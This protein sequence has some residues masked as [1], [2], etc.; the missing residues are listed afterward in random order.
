MPRLLTGAD[1]ERV[2]P[3]ELCIAAVEDALRQHAL[4][5]VPEPG[6][7]GMH[8]GV[9]SFHVKAGSLRVE[10]KLYFAAK[11]NANFPGNPG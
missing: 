11:L 1:V 8:E 6:I 7:L 5:K 4:G 3:P 2:L 10:G 9:G